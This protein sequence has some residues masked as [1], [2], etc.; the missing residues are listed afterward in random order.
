M[1]VCIVFLMFYCSCQPVLAVVVEGRALGSG[2]VGGGIPVD[3]DQVWGLQAD[4]RVLEDDALGVLIY[5]YVYV[6]I[7][8]CCMCIYIYI[9]CVYIYIYR[10]RERYISLSIYIYIYI[11]VYIY[12]YIYIYIYVYTCVY[13]YIYTHVLH[14]ALAKVHVAKEGD[15]EGAIGSQLQRRARV[16]GAQ[17][18]PV[19]IYIYI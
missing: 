15:L 3:D 10:E 18:G 12:I 14:R 19:Y 5:M 17:G 4:Q 8:I 6:C 9:V 13:I 16:R 11:Y 2:V 1:F 7:Y